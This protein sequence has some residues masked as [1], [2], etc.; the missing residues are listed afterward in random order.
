MDTCGGAGYSSI[1]LLSIIQRKTA[2]AQTI[3]KVRAVQ[4]S[5]QS[6][7]CFDRSH[8]HIK[9]LHEE[10][11]RFVC[12]TPLLPLLACVPP[13]L[14]KKEALL[15]KCSAAPTCT[16]A[17]YTTSHTRNTF[18]H[19][20]NPPTILHHS[21][22]LRQFPRTSLLNLAL[23]THSLTHS[24]PT[25][26]QPHT[27]HPSLSQ[28]LLSNND[29]TSGR[30][31]TRRREKIVLVTVSGNADF[32]IHPSRVLFSS[33]LIQLSADVN[34]F[35]QGRPSS[36]TT[37]TFQN[38]CNCRTPRP[39]VHRSPHAPALRPKSLPVLRQ[40][41]GVRIHYDRLR[42]AR[43]LDRRAARR[44]SHPEALAS[45]EHEVPT[46]TAPEILIEAQCFCH[47]LAF[48]PLVRHP[49]CVAT[50]ALKMRTTIL[51]HHRQTYER[52]L[53]IAF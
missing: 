7:N 51:C 6:F 24:S 16:A 9:N 27:P 3:S 12:G 10:I 11:S 50:H 41:H 32:A 18:P 22:L 49:R 21:V 17:H 53:A 43:V 1:L 30:Q 2:P 34:I 47:R 35:C 42:A 36:D 5:T 26:R 13:H 20:P 48:L 44:R 52:T 45:E 37:P 29:K 4:Y 40:A 33:L 46:A 15:T 28:L 38:P 39:V 31:P 8:G 25:I 19:T 14:I 23:N